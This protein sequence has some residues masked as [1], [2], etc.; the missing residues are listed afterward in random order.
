MLRRNPDALA[1]AAIVFFLL[2]PR[3]PIYVSATPFAAPAQRTELRDCIRQ[4]VRTLVDSLR[5]K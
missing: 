3:V 5:L 4:S 2:I 1:L